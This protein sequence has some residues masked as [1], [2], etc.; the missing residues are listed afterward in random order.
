MASAKEAAARVNEACALSLRCSTTA[1]R[2]F[3]T[4]PIMR[5]FIFVID[6][7][8]LIF[9]QRLVVWSA[10]GER[11]SMAPCLGIAGTSRWSGSVIATW[12]EEMDTR[13]YAQRHRFMPRPFTAIFSPSAKKMSGEAHLAGVWKLADNQS[14][15]SHIISAVCV[16]YS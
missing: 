9:R 13:V 11:S 14:S 7:L 12:V 1:T 6:S 8:Y 5:S 2:F 10:P 15:S 4:K 3:Y 16:T